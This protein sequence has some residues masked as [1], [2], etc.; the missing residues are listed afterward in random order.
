MN[1]EIYARLREE[2]KRFEG[3]EGV[4]YEKK[5]WPDGVLWGLVLGIVVMIGFLVVMSKFDWRSLYDLFVAVF[6]WVVFAAVAYG[7]IVL[8]KWVIQ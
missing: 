8:F 4:E 7:V 3:L 2:N 6:I 5:E 1:K